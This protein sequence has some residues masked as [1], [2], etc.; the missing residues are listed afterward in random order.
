MHELSGTANGI[1]VL[2]AAIDSVG[3]KSQYLG[4]GNT[5]FGSSILHSGEKTTSVVWNMN[6]G[7]YKI[8][9]EGPQEGEVSGSIQQALEGA[10]TVSSLKPREMNGPYLVNERGTPLLES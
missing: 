7:Q 5:G 6:G 10:G 3:G 4:K 1:D 9:V 8:R 2:K